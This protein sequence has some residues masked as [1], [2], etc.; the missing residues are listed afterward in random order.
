MM[1]SLA[2]CIRQRL[3]KR[4]LLK[5]RLADAIGTNPSN[6]SSQRREP[7]KGRLA[8]AIGTNP[9]NSSSQRREPLKGNMADTSGTNPSNSSSLSSKGTKRFEISS[10]MISLQC[11]ALRMTEGYVDKKRL[12]HQGESLCC[13]RGGASVTYGGM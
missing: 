4:E 8:D 5:G 7:L 6:S 9:S 3:Q 10:R 2:R 1:L 12:L 11:K 13:F